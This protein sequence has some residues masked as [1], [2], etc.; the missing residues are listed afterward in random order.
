[1][2]R[3]DFF[4]AARGTRNARLLYLTSNLPIDNAAYIREIPTVD[5]GLLC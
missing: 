2:Y 4:S 3:S 5:R 1:L